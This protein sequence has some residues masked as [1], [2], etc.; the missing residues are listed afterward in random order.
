[1]SSSAFPDRPFW[2]RRAILATKH[3]KERAIAPILVPELQLKLTVPPDFDTDAFGTFT[4]D[5]ARRGSQL[6]AARAKADAALDLTGE[7]L[8][9]ASEGAFGPHPGLPF[10][11]QNVEIV[12]LRDRQYNLELVGRATSTETNFAHRQVTTLEDAWEFAQKVGFPEHGLV[13]APADPRDTKI[14][15]DDIEKGI[16]DSDR[17]KTAV[18]A[19]IARSGSA[20]LESDMRAMVNPTRMS[21]IAAATRDLLQKLHQHCPQCNAP[22]FDIAEHRPGLPCAACGLP[23]FA[24]KAVIYRCHHCHFE[25]E[26][27]R[28]DGRRSADPGTCQFCNP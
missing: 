7:T 26:T 16:T 25:R 24:P 3:R 15:G 20:H 17:L 12:V 13:V 6:D 23:T 14:H 11:T 8:G 9:L 22:G 19:A 18:K 1:M 2:G 10:V 21:V 5:I 4:G 27:P 28:P